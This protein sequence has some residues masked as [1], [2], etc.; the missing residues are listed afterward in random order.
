METPDK[1]A[2]KSETIVIKFGAGQESWAKVIGSQPTHERKLTAVLG[3]C[4]ASLQ[5]FDPG[6]YAVYEAMTAEQ[7]ATCDLFASL[8]YTTAIGINE[9][10]KT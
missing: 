7:K 2:I 4:L 6:I 3:F 5:R 8:G 10:S 9:P 1:P